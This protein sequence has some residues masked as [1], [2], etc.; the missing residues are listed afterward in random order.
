MR[1]LLK[2]MLFLL[3]LQILMTAAFLL[4]ERRGS[5]EKIML[6]KSGQVGKQALYAFEPNT[7]T[8]VALTKPFE[9][10]RLFYRA[11]S[12]WVYFLA[13]NSS[14]TTSQSTLYRLNIST[15]VQEE[16]VGG[17]RQ[18]QLA[19]QSFH[20]GE[21]T[22]SSHDEN[23]QLNVYRAN[24]ESS[25]VN[26]IALPDEISN[27]RTTSGPPVVLT[28]PNGDLLFFGRQDAAAVIYRMGSDGQTVRQI[29]SLDGL[30]VP[31]NLSIYAD[32]LF[33]QYRGHTYRI[34]TD[35]SQREEFPLNPGIQQRLYLSY[36]IPETQQLIVG[37]FPY[38]LVGDYLEIEWLGYDLHSDGREPLWALNVDLAESMVNLSLTPDGQWYL[39]MDRS[40]T[41][42]NFFRIRP[43]GTQRQQL[44]DLPGIKQHPIWSNDGAWLL[45]TAAA[46]GMP[47]QKALYRVRPDGSDL[48]KIA[49]VPD[50]QA[51]QWSE[52]DRWITYSSRIGS[53]LVL[54]GVQHDGSQHRQ[55]TD[56]DWNV[57][58]WGWM[59]MPGMEWQP[60][61][62][63]GGGFALVAGLVATK[64]RLR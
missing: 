39:Y 61:I 14:G 20:D 46:M 10:L 50:P 63:L 13:S 57:E 23:N 21:F 4:V 29:A 43:D 53:N 56:A 33:Y 3:A 25:P 36:L 6:I 16:V 38:S 41:G 1:P 47:N 59:P 32:W 52:D 55:L 49:D 28:L 15:L 31:T 60:S 27:L 26:T 44:T 34:G 37:L 11:A 19:G 30:D 42:P 45:F 2:L 18:A 5:P 7:Q 24:N 9:G 8:A 35:G 62:L 48:Y 58:L 12:N 51:L 40:E 64:K 54:Y 17:V 22:F